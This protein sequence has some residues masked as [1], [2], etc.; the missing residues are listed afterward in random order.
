[1]NPGVT[2]PPF[3]STNRALGNAL[4]SF[5]ISALDPTETILS[6]PT[7]SPVAHG[8][9]GLAVHTRAL[10]TNRVISSDRVM[11]LSQAVST[12]AVRIVA[13]LRFKPAPQLE[14]AALRLH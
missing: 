13:R 4:A 2:I 9:F 10:T 5:A 11:R 14:H 12:T 8:C 1:M 6:P 3:A 7:A